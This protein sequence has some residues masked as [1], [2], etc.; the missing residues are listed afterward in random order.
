MDKPDKEFKQKLVEDGDVHLIVEEGA[1]G[2]PSLPAT[3][4]GASTTDETGATARPKS[5]AENKPAANK[6]AA[7]KPAAKSMARRILNL[8]LVAFGALVFGVVAISVNYWVYMQGAMNA[9]DM[10][11]LKS[12]MQLAQQNKLTDAEH[13]LEPFVFTNKNSSHECAKALA[14]MY[15]FDDK[16]DRMEEAILV[17][18]CGDKKRSPRHMLHLSAAM[19]ESHPAVA[20]RV[21]ERA[22]ALEKEANGVD[23]DYGTIL[24]FAAIDEAKTGQRDQAIE[25]LKVAI[26]LLKQ[27]PGQTPFEYKKAEAL[28]AELSAAPQTIKPQ[29]DTKTQQSTTTAGE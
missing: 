18:S 3:S 5:A 13:T 21:L 26:P 2:E 27:H 25:N 14:A 29:Q 6:P 20:A 4:N 17:I 19:E 12:A 15:A 7:N 23:R 24:Y 28:L 1:G 10:K 16:F 8:M 11:A 9:P 22:A